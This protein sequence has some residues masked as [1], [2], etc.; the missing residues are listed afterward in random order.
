M[1]EIEHLVKS[2]VIG[3]NVVHALNDVSL[4]VSEREFVAIVGPSGSGKST[5][6]NIIGC[7]DIATS[8]SYKLR[9][10]EISL[11]TEDELSEFRNRMIGFI[12]QRFNLLNKLNA[13]ENVEL[14]LVYQG[15]SSKERRERAVAALEKV[16]LANRMLHTPMELSGGQQQRVAIARALITDPPV[17]LADEPTGNLDSTTGKEVMQILQGLGSAGHTIVLITHD[18]NIAKQARRIV[19]ISDGRLVSDEEVS[20][21]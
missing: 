8:G 6:M 15:I 18:M 14:P 20:R 4:S 11:Y 21:S 10:Q 3:D 19:R 1:I 2:Y 5:L 12:F 9:G 16:R 7:L 17:I 13:V